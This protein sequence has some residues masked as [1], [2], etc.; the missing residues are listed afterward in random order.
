VSHNHDGP[1]ARW[2]IHRESN[3]LTK[4]SRYNKRNQGDIIL[5]SLHIPKCWWL[6]SIFGSEF[7][8]QLN[9]FARANLNS[10]YVYHKRPY[11]APNAMVQHFIYLFDGMSNTC[12]W[13][14]ALERLFSIAFYW[15]DLCSKLHND[16]MIHL[17]LRCAYNFVGNLILVYKMI[18]SLR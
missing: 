7:I 1:H 17:N 4:V 16:K 12:E 11:V 9:G 10:R 3:H 18:L 15:Y 8:F 14:S 2:L 13:I 5:V 6:I